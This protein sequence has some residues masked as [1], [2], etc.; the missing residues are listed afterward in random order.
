[1]AALVSLIGSSRHDERTASDLDA[2]PVSPFV[3]VSADGMAAR[4]ETEGRSIAGIHAINRTQG[5]VLG[6]FILAWMTLAVILLLSSSVRD[7]T[8]PRVLG[9]GT[10]AVLAFLVGLLAFLA[11]LGIGVTRRWRWL[12]WLLFLAFAA[13]LA[14]VPVTILQLAGQLSPEGPDWYLVLQ[15][16][17]GVVQVGLACAMFTGYRRAGPWG[18]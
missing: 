8:L 18:A 15:G 5:L 17:A 6:F 10:P 14:R 9:T 4:N 13:G 16:V 11:V 1:M 7:V 3:V 2:R 12:F